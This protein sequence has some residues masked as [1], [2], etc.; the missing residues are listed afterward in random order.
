MLLER[1]EVYLLPVELSLA[2]VAG[3]VHR[4]IVSLGVG[5]IDFVVHLLKD[6]AELLI[7]DPCNIHPCS[8]F[9]STFLARKCFQNHVLLSHRDR[10]SELLQDPYEVLEEDLALV[11]SVGYLLHRVDETAPFPADLPVDLGEDLD[12][13]VLVH[14]LVDFAVVLV[15]LSRLP[16]LVMLARVH[17]ALLGLVLSEIE[18]LLWEHLRAD[19]DRLKILAN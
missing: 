12:G 6:Y 14:L 15:V 11:F 5:D 4:L 19:R 10:D 18:A 3:D 17:L 2:K 1:H 9:H 8:S 13:L 16:A 7:I